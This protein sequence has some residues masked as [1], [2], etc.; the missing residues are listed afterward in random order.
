M[1][2]ALSNQTALE[3]LRARIREPAAREAFDRLVQVGKVRQIG[4]STF[5]P[6]QLEE[7][8]ALAGERGWIRPTSEQPPYSALARGIETEVLPLLGRLHVGAIVWAPL[9]GG[10]L[11][12]KYQAATTD[13]QSRALRQPEHFDHRDVAMREEKRRLVDQL[14]ADR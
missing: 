6:A 14:A 11:T 1:K 3:T 5:S 8:H 12:G 4:T 13:E 2:A 7:L 9:N 10:W